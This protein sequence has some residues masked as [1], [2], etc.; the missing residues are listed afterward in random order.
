MKKVCVLGLGYIGLPTSIIMAERGLEVVGFDVNEQRVARINQCDP[1]IQEPEIFER[2]QD[3]VR[4]KL[5]RASTASEEADYFVIAV[6]TPFTEQKKADLSYVLSAAKTVAQVLRPGNVVILESTVPVGA[7]KQLAGVLEKETGLTVGKD[8]FVA[9]CPER[10]LPGKIFRE[11]VHNARI[12]GGMTPACVEKTKKLYKY[13]VKGPL[14]LTDATTAEMVKLVENSSRD[15]AIAFAN[16]VASMAY[17][18]GLDP[19]EVIELANKHPRVNILRPGCGVGGHCIAVDPWFLVEGFPQQ[20]EL[21]KMA[22]EVNDAKPQ[23]V[24]T[25]VKKQITTWQKNNK[26]TCN[27]LV[28]GLTYKPDVDDLRESPALSIAQDLVKLAQQQRTKAHTYNVMV[29][30][31]MVPQ[32]LVEKKI[33]SEIVSLQE[34]IAQA[35]IIVSLVAHSLFREPLQQIAH[36]KI[37]IDYCGLLHKPREE[38]HEQEKLFWPA[39]SDYTWPE[40]DGLLP[41]VHGKQEKLV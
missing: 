20:T 17:E 3:V 35:D 40:F 41:N 31:P 2:L 26:R 24:L 1:V 18:V 32:E 34:G 27:V 37:V 39:S 29:C 5:F 19:Y 7:T 16:Q 36:Q 21:I 23:E 38:S 15:V 30:E 10:V 14:Y 9:H 8:F 12:I 4:K 25:A 28:L 6:P 33:A 13:F 11:L 22:R